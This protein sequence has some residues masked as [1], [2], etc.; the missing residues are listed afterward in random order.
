MDAEKDDRAPQA[1]GAVGPPGRAGRVLVPLVDE[2]L[3]AENPST[4]TL[5]DV[6]AIFAGDQDRDLLI[7]GIVTVPPQTPLAVARDE[8]VTS[9]HEDALE[10]ILETARTLTGS[11]RAL[12]NLAR[13]AA[14]SVIEAQAR[15]RAESVVI[16]VDGG[17]RV[18]RLLLGDTVESVLASV[19]CD[20]A[21]VKP[22]EFSGAPASLMFAVRDGPHSL[23]AA[24]RA[25]ALCLGYGIE[26]ATVLHVLGAGADRDDRSRVDALLEAVERALGPDVQARSRIVEAD[27]PKDTVLDEAIRHDVTVL[28]ATT[29][30]WLRRLAFGSVPDE[31]HQGDPGLVVT[32][33]A[34]ERPRD[35]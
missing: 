3:D 1:P 4:R 9:A 31:V 24:A 7:V 32:A 14:N 34:R 28:G 35:G 21:T 15:Y 17:H 5:I 12:L 19:E 13:G 10:E 25:R 30:S 11:A 6:A 20:A 8:A 26:A 22:A 29:A 16:G 33:K 23:L 18:R 27:A 2:A